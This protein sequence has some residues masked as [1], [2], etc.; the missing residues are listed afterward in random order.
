MAKLLD[1]AGLAGDETVLEVGP[2]TG[3]L[4]E[5]LLD[6]ARRVVAVEIDHGLCRQLQQRLGDRSRL[7]LICRDVLSG[8]HAISG[9]VLAAL[10]G[11]AVLVAN[12]P[13]AI[14]T[15]LIAQCLLDS[16]RA[17]AGDGGRCRF[18]RLTFTIQR[19]LADRLTARP[20]S[21]AYGPVSVLVALLGTVKLGPAVPPSAFWPAPK[22]ASRMV[23]IDFDPKAARKI[24]DMEALRSLLELAFSQRRKQLGSVLRSKHGKSP[25]QAFGDALLPAGIDPTLRAEEVPPE[26]FARLAD[27]LTRP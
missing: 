20:R 27:I 2:G 9:E 4:T 7:V 23:R 19:E 12:L 5:E 11:R 3:S 18:D 1:L 6:R 8:K 26:K 21:D 10:G 15:P 14:A 25:M 24:P 17:V 13:Y 22:V 16:W